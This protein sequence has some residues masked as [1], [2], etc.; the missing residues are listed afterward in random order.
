MLTLGVG[1]SVGSGFKSTVL[2]IG[3]LILDITWYAATLRHATTP[4][5]CASPRLICRSP[6]PLCRIVNLIISIVKSWDTPAE[7][8]CGG[9]GGKSGSRVNIVPGNR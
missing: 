3:S 8:V 7:K 6:A 4:G 1:S 9:G 2:Y 5:G